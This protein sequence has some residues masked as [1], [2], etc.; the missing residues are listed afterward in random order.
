M[1]PKKSIVKKGQ[2]ESSFGANLPNVP[3]V[4]LEIE[5]VLKEWGVSKNLY[6][7]ITLSIEEAVTNVIMHNGESSEFLNKPISIVLLNQD[8]TVHITISDYGKQF[9]IHSVSAP[10]METYNAQR[11]IG[12]FGIKLIKKLMDQVSLTRNND[13]NTLVMNKTLY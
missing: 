7:D 1:D 13:I 4:C 12:G 5:N 6:H 8:N 3:H 11:S 2:W 10:N 9:D